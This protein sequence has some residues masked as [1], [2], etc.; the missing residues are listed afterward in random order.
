MAKR[1]VAIWFRHLTTDYLVRKRPELKDI[2]FV[3][4]G[5]ERGRMVVKAVNDI[6]QAKG[7]STDMVV[8]DC[9][10]ILPSLKVIDDDIN[11][12]G[13]VL[14]ALAEWCMRYTPSVAIELP[15]GLLL[16]ISG[17]AHLWGGEEPYLKN[18]LTRLRD[19]GYH[20]RAAMADTIGAAWAVSR[21]G[22]LTPIIEPGKHLEALLSL[23]P[24]AL[25]LEASIITRLD[26]LGLHQVRS[27]IN[28]P[29]S[30][31]RR[32]FGQALLSRLDQALG[33]EIEVL[34]PVRPIEAH[35]ER[36]PCLEPIRTAKGIEIALSKL[37]DKLCDRLRK[38]GK[39]LRQSVFK[40]Y[41]IDGN[42]QQ[43]QI[44]TNRASRNVDHLFRLFK[45][46]I[47]TIE[48]ALG[49][50]LFII[51]APIV[52]DV[53]IEQEAIWE[54]STAKDE[55]KV[56]E[57]LDTIS[58]KF[59]SQAIQR[60]L[61]AEHYWPERSIIPATSLQDKP[62]TAWRID[63]PRPVHLL[64]VPEPITV[65]AP[66]PDY[67]PMHFIYKGNVHVVD[68]SD[69]PE[70]IEQE[71]WIQQGLYRD[72]YCIE[73]REGKRYWIFRL[74]SY[75]TGEPKWFIHGFFA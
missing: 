15:D 48:P 52:E 13:K 57:L 32:R 59:G 64:T 41:R 60:Y 44:G 43:I 66:I 1:F 38:E 37:L 75:H 46:K 30:A 20:V 45:L 42:I 9:R 21:Y 40:G 26:K 6:A 23:P 49:F 51:E 10:A 69:G 71:W 29:R 53:A 56:A 58:G 8:A 3:L 47:P 39:G 33:Q 18:I 24:A 4:A 54:M 16:D 27:F 19:Y 14:S 31:L 35:Q 63:L 68:K 25:R 11:T 73:D 36:L 55:A 67:P 50:E 72:Y 61:P 5:P 2:P 28:M 12:A 22:Q 70:R 74:G 34:E 65:A 7:I 17:C 62:S